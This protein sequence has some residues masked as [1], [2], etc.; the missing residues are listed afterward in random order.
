MNVPGDSDNAAASALQSQFARAWSTR[1]VCP[2]GRV[3]GTKI[4]DP[5]NLFCRK[6]Q[7]SN[8]LDEKLIYADFSPHLTRE[9]S[10][11]TAAIFVHAL[12]Y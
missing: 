4:A 9:A 10:A 8:F 12:A 3:D 1:S 2:A 7:C 11:A 6:S 5:H